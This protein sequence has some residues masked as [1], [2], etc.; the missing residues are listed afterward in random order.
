MTDTDHTDHA[1][2]VAAVHDIARWLEQS[3]R[4]GRPWERDALAA[5][6]RSGHWRDMPALY[7]DA[8]IL[9]RQATRNAGVGVNLGPDGPPGRVRPPEPLPEAAQG[10]SKAAHR[11]ATADPTRN[12]PRE[13]RP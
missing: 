10:P 5:Q 4:H 3:A 6:L 11:P 1:Y 13:D 8:A 9:E 2:Y 12:T 7:S